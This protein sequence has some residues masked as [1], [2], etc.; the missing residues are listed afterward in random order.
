[1]FVSS[2]HYRKKEEF[3]ALADRVISMPVGEMEKNIQDYLEIQ[4]GNTIFI[5]DS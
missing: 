3:D 4:V 5:V 2:I 1:M